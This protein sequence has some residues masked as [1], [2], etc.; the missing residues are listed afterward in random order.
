MASV[1]G[2][3][4]GWSVT[5]IVDGA[6]GWPIVAAAITIPRIAVTGVAVGGI[7]VA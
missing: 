2:R 3:T 6:I 1:D 4:V 7:A 5:A